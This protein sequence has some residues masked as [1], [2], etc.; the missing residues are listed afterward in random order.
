MTDDMPQNSGLIFLVD[1][2]KSMRD[3]TRQWL[4]LAGF[5]VHD[6]TRAS[7]ALERIDQGFRGVLVSDIK[8]PGMDGIELQSRVRECD[9]DIPVILVTGHGDIAL[10]VQAMRAGAYD[11]IEK[12]F[13]PE[14]LLDIVQRAQEKRAL[15]LDNRNLMRDLAASE[16]LDGRLVG[17]SPEMRRLK[18]EIVD[19]APTNASVLIS[20]PTGSGKE[21]VARCLHD[22]GPN[23]D[24]PFIAVNCAAIPTQMAESE[25][26]GHTRG[27]FTGAQAC[28]QGKLEAANGGT[29]FLDELTSTPMDVQGKLLRALEEHVVVPLGSNK[30]IPVSFRLVAAIQE[31]PEEAVQSGRLRK[32]LFYRISTIALKI[33]ALNARREDIGL[34]F[35]LFSNLA[36]DAYGREVPILDAVGYAAMMAHD[37]SGN[38]RELKNVAERFV[39]SSLPLEDRLAHLLNADEQVVADGKLSLAEQVRLYE[40]NLLQEALTRHGGNISAVMEDLAIPRRTLNEKMMKYALARHPDKVE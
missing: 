17:H 38:V 7:A 35:K 3:A 29:L 1:D 24:G 16:G 9:P 26:F 14:H 21:V 30:E 8:M 19:F 23:P 37:W 31:D 10:A 28:R 4:E 2:E 22:L 39:L 5:E 6:F 18:R 12:P 36:G 34:L 27:A 11:F 32:D 33:P 13:A 40:K 20:G 25:F 15:V